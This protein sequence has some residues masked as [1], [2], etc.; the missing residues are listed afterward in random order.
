[1]NP[2]SSSH[3][4]FELDKGQKTYQKGSLG[5]VSF[6]EPKILQAAQIIYRYHLRVHAAIMEPPLGVIINRNNLRGQ[7]V[8]SVK[9][10][11][12]PD[13]CFIPLAQME[14]SIY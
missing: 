5:I 8:F 7:I 14:A 13:E 6:P 1:M 2:L 3:C 11:L 9:P 4:G 10:I 12:L